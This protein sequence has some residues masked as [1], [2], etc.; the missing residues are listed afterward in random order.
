MEKKLYESKM[1]V[2]TILNKIGISDVYFG[3]EI[4]VELLFENQRDNFIDL[5]YNKF[6]NFLLKKEMSIICGVEIV[7]AP[8]T[9][10]IMIN[11]IKEVILF[12]NENNAKVS[13]RTGLHIHIS[14]TNDPQIDL[15]IFQFVNNPKNREEIIDFIPSSNIKHT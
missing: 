5:F 4:E 15:K 7:S 1:D 9:L 11:E 10:D 13:E 12:C 8:M 2:L 14:K 6:T 3:I